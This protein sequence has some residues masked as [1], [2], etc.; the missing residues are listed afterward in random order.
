MP[1]VF[2]G[3]LINVRWGDPAFSVATNLCDYFSLGTEEGEGHW[4]EGQMVGPDKEIVFNGRIFFPPSNAA[5]A[6][7]G[8]IID[9][10]PRGPVPAGW[11]RYQRDNGYDLVDR[12]GRT[13]FGYTVGDDGTCV[14]TVNIYT[15][16]GELAAESTDG[17]LLV[18]KGPARLGRNGIA[19]G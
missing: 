2:G 17:S 9:N 5:E 19:I 12:N 11:T 15:A 18:H 7:N 10:F 6:V 16:E 13:L 1:A 8:E 4:I 14:V 3:N